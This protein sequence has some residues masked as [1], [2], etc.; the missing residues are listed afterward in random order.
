MKKIAILSVVAALSYAVAAEKK[1]KLEDLPPAVQKTAQDQLKGAKLSGISTE[2]EGG[3]TLYEVE[4]DRNGKSRDVLIDKTGKVAETEDEVDLASIPAPAKSAIEKKAGKDKIVKVV[5]LTKSAGIEAYEAQ[6]KKG[7][8]TSEYAVKP[9]GS[10][11][12][13]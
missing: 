7:S 6:I 4:M 2:T 9:D 12:K 13:D 10:T 3:K 8:K 1:L 5:S 11:Y